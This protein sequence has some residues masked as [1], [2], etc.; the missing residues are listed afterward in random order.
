MKIIAVANQKGGVGKTTTAVNAAAC[1]AE[2]GKKVL[3]IDSDPQGNASSGVGIAREEIK[4]SIYNLIIEE[5]DMK[6]CI[7]QTKYKNLDILPSSTALSGAEIELISLPEREFR[8]KNALKNVEGYDFALIDCPPSLG[9]ITL[10]AF[11]AADSVLIP[12][13]CEYYALEGVAQLTDTI[14][15]VRRSLN[16]QLAIEGVVMTMFDARTNLSTEV[17]NEVKRAFPKMVYSSI[18]P[19]NIR[20]SE[21][22]GFGESIIDFDTHSKGAEMYRSLAK[23]IIAANKGKR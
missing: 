19:R 11:A 18:I 15:R 22:P 3:L 5:K 17:V 8:L 4:N 7:L 6:D 13:Q 9:L 2:K 10:N 16:P 14:K 1:L 21:A 23:E 12:I 20:L